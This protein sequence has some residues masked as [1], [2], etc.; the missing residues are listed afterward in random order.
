[1]SVMPTLLS[2]K[3][4][5]STEFLQINEIDFTLHVLI[6]FVSDGY[7]FIHLRSY[8]HRTQRYELYL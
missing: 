3:S 4:S 6:V 2:P 1:M 5:V 7:L 8:A